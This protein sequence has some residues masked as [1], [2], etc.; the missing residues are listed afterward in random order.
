MQNNS[1]EERYEDEIVCELNLTLYTDV[2]IESF[3]D[4]LYKQIQ[5]E[6]SKNSQRVKK[7]ISIKRSK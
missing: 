6:Q 1:I 2:L 4:L 7:G 3:F 5:L